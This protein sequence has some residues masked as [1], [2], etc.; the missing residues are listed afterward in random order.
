M[1]LDNFFQL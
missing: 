1:I